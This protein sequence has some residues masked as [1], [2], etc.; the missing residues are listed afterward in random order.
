MVVGTQSYFRETYTHIHIDHSPQNF[1]SS[2]EKTRQKTRVFR[3]GL[4]LLVEYGAIMPDKKA[5]CSITLRIFI[6]S[7]G[8]A[9]Q[10]LSEYDE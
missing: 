10:N 5:N 1:Y 3:V 4:A 9:Y 6:M 2:S 7:H 8:G